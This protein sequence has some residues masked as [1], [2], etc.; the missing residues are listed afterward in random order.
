MRKSIPWVKV[1]GVLTVIVAVG[2]SLLAGSPR[3]AATSPGDAFFGTVCPDIVA[4]VICSNGRIYINGCYAAKAGATG[5]HPYN[6]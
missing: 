3:A 4:P 2:V 5:C 1:L 6:L